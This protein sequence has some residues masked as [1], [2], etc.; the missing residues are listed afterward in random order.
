MTEDYNQSLCR[1]Y[2]YVRNYYRYT[3]RLSSIRGHHK[4]NRMRHGWTGLVLDRIRVPD[5]D[6]S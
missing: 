4:Q 1:N 6:D 2:A 3:A 5:S